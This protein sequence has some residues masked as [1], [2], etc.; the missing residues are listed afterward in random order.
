MFPHDIDAER[1]I[2]SLA[3]N[4]SNEFLLLKTNLNFLRSFTWEENEIIFRSRKG[5]FFINFLE[6]RKGFEERKPMADLI[7]F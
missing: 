7:D 6:K 5:I 4:T 1:H 3:Y 2:S